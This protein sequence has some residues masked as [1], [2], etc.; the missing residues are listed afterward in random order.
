MISEKWYLMALLCISLMTNEARMLFLC[1]FVA[2]LYGLFHILF[3]IFPVFVWVFNS[4]TYDL[5]VFLLY[6]I[7][8]HIKTL[9][10]CKGLCYISIK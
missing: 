5:Q 4:F 1:M 3:T 7:F 10:S 6:G 2:H 8:S 9:P